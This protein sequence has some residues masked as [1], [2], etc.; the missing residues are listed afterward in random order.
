MIRGS[1]AEYF[2]SMNGR[3]QWPDR[4][5]PRNHLVITTDNNEQNITH[6]FA[7]VRTSPVSFLHCG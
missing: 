1:L 2:R 7:D 3:I 5:M 6:S 4:T